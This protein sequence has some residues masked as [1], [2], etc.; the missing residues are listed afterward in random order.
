[1]GVGRDDRTAATPG[2]WNVEGDGSLRLTYADASRGSRRL[3]IVENDASILK[4][5]VRHD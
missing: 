3:E 2:S 5:Q 4:V 1:M